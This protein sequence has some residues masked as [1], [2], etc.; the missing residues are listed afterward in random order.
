MNRHLKYEYTIVSLFITVKNKELRFTTKIL[1][2]LRVTKNT[3]EIK[4]T[5]KKH[6]CFFDF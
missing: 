4:Y 1:R 5:K 3:R 6:K 2:A